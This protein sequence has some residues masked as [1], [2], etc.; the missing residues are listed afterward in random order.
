MCRESHWNQLLFQ[1]K[2]FVTLVFGMNNKHQTLSL[3]IWFLSICKKMK[4]KNL[5]HF[6]W[7]YRMIKK[8][9]TIGF[10]DQKDCITHLRHQW[11]IATIFH[12]KFWIIHRLLFETRHKYKISIFRVIICQRWYFHLIL[13]IHLWH[14]WTC[15][16]VHGAFRL[17]FSI[18]K[19]SITNEIHLME[20]MT[21]RFVNAV[22]LNL[23]LCSIRYHHWIWIFSSSF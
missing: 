7:I 13:S 18:Y 23:I 17:N 22:W 6:G 10:G 3:S 5:T 9:N 19:P 16:F 11:I 20:K 4:V 1:I 2:I 15:C 12:L 8:S 21:V 14:D